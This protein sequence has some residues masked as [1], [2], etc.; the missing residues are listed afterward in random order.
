[1]DLSNKISLNE[2][3]SSIINEFLMT[4]SSV[5]KLPSIL[6]LSTKVLSRSS[7]LIKISILLLLVIIWS[8]LAFK[9]TKLFLNVN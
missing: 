7:S 8:K 9:K 6:I 1:M 5:I 2:S 3:P 4:F